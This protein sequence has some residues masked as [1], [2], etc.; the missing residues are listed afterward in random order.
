MISNDKGSPYK[1]YAFAYDINTLKPGNNCHVG[2]LYY[3]GLGVGVWLAELEF[4]LFLLG[5]ASG[6]TVRHSTVLI[7]A[8]G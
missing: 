6:E 5:V 3:S 1:S 8:I 2:Q 7:L 4:F